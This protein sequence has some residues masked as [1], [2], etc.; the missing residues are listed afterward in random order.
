[1]K[2]KVLSRSLDAHTPARLGD[3]APTSR[4]L[5]PALHPF[6]K[7]REY[8]RALN[9]SKL[10]RMFAKPFV[11]ALEG[12]IDGIYSI[13]T[14][15]SRLS[16]CASGSGDGEIRLW[17]LTQQSL[18][19]SF[20][21]AHSGIIQSLAFSSS[22]AST[23][24]VLISCSTDAT[25]KV[26]NADPHP[27]R[28]GFDGNAAGADAMGLDSEDEDEDQDEEGNGF[29]EMTAGGDARRGG[30]LSMQQSDRPT[31]EPLSIY[32]GRSAFSC[33]TTHASLPHFA[34]ASSSIQIWDLNRAGTSG[35]G[36]EALQT[37]Q[38]AN[39]GET[40]NV[41]RF[42]QSEREVL[43]STGTDRS[44]VLYDTRGGKPLSKMIMRMRAND[45]AW[46]PMEPTTFAVGSEDH[47]IYT[48]DM[49]NLKSATQ[50][51]KDHVAAV[52][53]VSYSPTGQELV[54]GSYD[55]TL[56]LWSV[57]QGAHSRDIYHTKRMQRIFATAF[58]LDARFV[59][60]GSDDGN[61]RLWKARASEK[62][63]ILNGREKAQ[64][65]YSEALRSKWS[66][67]AEVK[68]IERQRNVPKQIKQ[69]QT[70]KRTMLE[71]QRRKEDHRRRH[72]KKGNT[73]PQAA[74]KE[75]ILAIKE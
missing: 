64:L 27:D 35:T 15:P 20:P 48:F 14:D 30:L 26:W 70:L 38:W 41:V 1:M 54:S 74:R 66:G 47:N 34:S 75:A 29:G 9:A 11:A 63:G 46:S 10:N 53:S 2:V 28:T 71:A 51:Y 69:A 3:L 60:S 19:H 40:C 72:T 22:A 23:S 42:N 50:I 39:D 4:N 59:L 43:A 68:K 57:G 18:I 25:I 44:V 24:K 16:T 21:G 55:R 37:F 5:D 45:L 17:D 33:I 61:L 36:A 73:K 52:M 32:N 56:R 6:S 62:L 67:T 65:E 31:S 58:T 12:H 49:R 8:T 7:P 13:A